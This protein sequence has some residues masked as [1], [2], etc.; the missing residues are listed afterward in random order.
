MTF[1]PIDW[2]NLFLA[3]WMVAMVWAIGA[4][5]RSTNPAPCRE[6]IE[7]VDRIRRML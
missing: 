1:E 3:C 4:R 2:F 7:V 6:G 5:K